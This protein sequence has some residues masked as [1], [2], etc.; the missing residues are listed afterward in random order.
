MDSVEYKAMK[1]MAKAH[2][3]A[4]DEDSLK[5]F[6]NKIDKQSKIKKWASIF[7]V[8]SSIPLLLVGIGFFVFLCAIGL[9]FFGYKKMAKKAQSF[10]EHVNND[11]ELSAA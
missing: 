1:K 5:N 7:L 11:P 4:Y 6:A 10:K 8:I 2:L 9:Y 3:G